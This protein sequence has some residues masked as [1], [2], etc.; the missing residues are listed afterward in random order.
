MFSDRGA[1]YRTRRTSQVCRQWRNL[2]LNATSLWARLVDTEAL[3]HA[4]T[5]EWWNEL[6]RRSGT[7]PLWIRA[8]ST[9]FKPMNVLR[10]GSSKDIECFTFNLISNNWHRIQKLI[11]EGDSPHFGL[12]RAMLR[13]PAPQLEQFQAPLPKTDVGGLDQADVIT[14]PLFAGYAP[15]L[16]RL[17]AG[18]H[19]VDPKAPWLR[20]L[21]SIHIG[22]SYTVCDALAVLSA[23][24]SLQD[25]WLTSH[26]VQ[27]ISTHHFVVSLKYLKLLDY[28]GSA[29]HC[30]ALLDRVKLPPHC[31]LSIWINFHDDYEEM[32]EIKRTLLPVINIFT[33]HLNRRLQLQRFNIIS[34]NSM[35]NSDIFLKVSETV[36]RNECLFSL[37]IPYNMDHGSMILDKLALLDLT[38]I[39]ELRFTTT[40]YVNPSFGHFFNCLLSL[41][42]IC[43]DNQSLKYLIFLQNNMPL[44]KDPSIFFPSLKVVNASH[45]GDTHWLEADVEDLAVFST[46]ILSRVQNGHPVTTLDMTRTCHKI[47]A[48]LDM[49]A[50]V[51]GLKVLYKRPLIPGIFEYTCGS[52][53]PEKFIDSF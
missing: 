7:A 20:H 53:E 38:R 21:L 52:D 42:T 30:A 43:I 10:P 51:K 17:H 39:T 27:D 16:L 32:A 22:S 35:P 3:C 5:R 26:A 37:S 33:R 12:T 44:A 48:D 49:Y 11:V 14:T 40:C 31:A 18:S 19:V 29:Q 25:V 47:P 23:T 41:E 6:I 4:S 36:F 46:F 8:S 13:F 28:L 45:T 1:L 2:I 34:L 24:H 50:E 15:Q 9:Q